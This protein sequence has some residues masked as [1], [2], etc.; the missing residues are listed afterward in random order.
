M[1]L[2]GKIILITG[3][4]YGIGKSCANFFADLGANLILT[5]NIIF[6]INC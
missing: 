4:S 6:L 1:N 2:K 3:A 5:Y